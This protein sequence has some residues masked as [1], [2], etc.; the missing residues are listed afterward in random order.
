MDEFIAKFTLLLCY[1]PYLRDE[2]AK[3]QRFL[4]SLP[5]HMKERIEFL[6]PKTMDEAIRKARLCYQQAK[7]KMDQGKGWQPRKENRNSAGAKRSKTSNFRSSAR[8]SINNQFG[9][10][11]QRIRWPGEDK[12]VEASSKPEQTQSQRP[13]LQCWGCGAAHYYRDFP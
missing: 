10:N 11:H 4:S 7:T 3:V 5:T 8:N 6:N 1:V 9:R 13:P 12:T 2:K